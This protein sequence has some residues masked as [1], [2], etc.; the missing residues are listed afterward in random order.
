M[1]DTTT[2]G[3]LTAEIVPMAAAFSVHGDLSR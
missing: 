3:D 2:Q 1:K